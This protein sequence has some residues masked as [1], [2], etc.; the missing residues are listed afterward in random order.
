MSAHSRIYPAYQEQ[1]EGWN[2]GNITAALSHL[3]YNR[4]KNSASWNLSSGLGTIL[5][6]RESESL[7]QSSLTLRNPTG[8][9][10]QAPLSM[11]Q[12]LGREDPLEKGMAT[13]S[14]ILTWRIPG[15][16]EPGR[17]QSMGSQ[18]VGHN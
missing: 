9:S 5:G 14:S 18:R 8:S 3:L 10:P 2:P 16:E 6:I 11:A 13:H 17:L 1:N 12:V 15:T 4:L 7:S